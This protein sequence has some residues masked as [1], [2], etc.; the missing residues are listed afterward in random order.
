MKD[1]QI[2]LAHHL[3]DVVNELLFHDPDFDVDDLHHRAFNE[4]YYIIGYFHAKEW[5]KKHD[6]CAFDAID[7]V[8]DYEMSNFGE[9]NTKINSESIV[10][11]LVY[12]E[13][14]KLINEIMSSNSDTSTL[15]NF[16]SELADFLIAFI[17]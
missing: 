2:E 14:E 8:R 15:I 12:I 9:F 10:N 7:Q 1:L 3:L 13:G 5:L 16:K 4:D 17:G 11:M 6:I